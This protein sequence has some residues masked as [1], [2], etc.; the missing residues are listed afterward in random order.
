MTLWEWLLAAAIGYC[1]FA[2]GTLFGFVIGVVAAIRGIQKGE[3]VASQ[4]R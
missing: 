4:D 2:A 3:I 1:L